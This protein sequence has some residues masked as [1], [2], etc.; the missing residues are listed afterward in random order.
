VSVVVCSGYPPRE[1][2]GYGVRFVRSFHRLWPESVGLMVY[3]EQTDPL[4]RD[5]CRPLWTIP[6][7]REFYER[8]RGNLAVQ[9]RDPSIGR[10]KPSEQRTGYSFKWDALKFFKQILIPG[11]AASAMKDGD[12]LVWLDGDVETTA[13][14]PEGWIESLIGDSELCY[15]GRS[16]MHSEIGFWAV[17]LNPRTRSFLAAIALLYTSDEVFRLSE[18]H[19]AFAWDH[20]RRTAGLIERNLTPTLPSGHVWPLS[21]LA[22]YTVHRKGARKKDIR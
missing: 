13:P 8:H 17:R 14:V 5:A 6:G 7:A 4:P 21:P 12:I 10:F 19:S 11:D 2:F 16:R 1:R 20:C 18:W 3:T 22:P 15:L 9:G